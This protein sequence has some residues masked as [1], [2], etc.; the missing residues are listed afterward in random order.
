MTVYA[1]LSYCVSE[2]ETLKRLELA[3]QKKVYREASVHANQLGQSREANFLSKLSP[4]TTR[5]LQP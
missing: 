5:D 3:S 2:L 4:T 1:E